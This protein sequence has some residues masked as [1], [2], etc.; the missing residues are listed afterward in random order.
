VRWG[1]QGGFGEKPTHPK[2]LEKLIHLGLPGR[3]KM[4]DRRPNSA[5]MEEQK[6]FSGKGKQHQDLSS[7]GRIQEADS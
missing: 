4:V 6:E 3:S 1:D 7:V 5:S 2:P